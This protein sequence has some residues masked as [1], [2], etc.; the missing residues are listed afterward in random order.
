MRTNKTKSNV[1][2]KEIEN[3]I[4][5]AIDWRIKM[6]SLLWDSDF[7]TQFEDEIDEISNSINNIIA[8]CAPILGWARVG[9]LG[10]Y[11][12]CDSTKAE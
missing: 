3:L 7:D 5:G 9:E 6:Q 12:A 11:M 1:T 10:D 4:T 8:K 2:S